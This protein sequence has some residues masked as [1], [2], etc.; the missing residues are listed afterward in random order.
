M[1]LLPLF[2]LAVAAARTA[3]VDDAVT[4]PVVQVE[5]VE[6]APVEATPVE[7]TEPAI[8]LDSAAAV[9]DDDVVTTPTAEPPKAIDTPTPPIVDPNTHRW[10]IAAVPTATFNTD[11]GFGTG[12]VV[13]LFHHHEGVTPFRNE[14][15]FNLFIS[16]ELIQAHAIT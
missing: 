2:V 11:E 5:A 13:S 6:A 16:S 14:L 1:L 3:R 8:R 12:G 7:A 9:S 15:R 4:A 10:T